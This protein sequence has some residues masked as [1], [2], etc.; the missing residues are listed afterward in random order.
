MEV[1]T[2]KEIYEVA[3]K[4]YGV[5]H[6]NYIG[7]GYSNTYKAVVDFNPDGSSHPVIKS[8]CVGQ[9]EKRMGIQ[10]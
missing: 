10:H 8:E 4:K 5:K 3:V 2:I 6:L 1:D 9:V 7:D